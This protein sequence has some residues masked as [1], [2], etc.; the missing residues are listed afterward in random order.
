MQPKK[1][2]I[3]RTVLL[4]TMVIISSSACAGPEVNENQNDAVQVGI[5]ETA[6]N[7][8][9]PEVFPSSTPRT[10]LPAE[11]TSTS[12]PTVELPA[13]TPWP[14]SE[15]FFDGLRVTFFNNA[16]FMITTGDVKILIDVLYDTYPARTAP[17]RAALQR[18]AR[19][20]APFDGVD[21]IIATHSHSDHFSAQLVRD[22]LAV[23]P[24]AV[25]ISSPDAVQEIGSQ[26]QAITERLIPVSIR[27]GESTTLSVGGIDLEFF[28]IT[29][30]DDSILNMGVLIRANGYT[31]FHSGDMNV[32]PSWGD[33][34]SREDLIAFGLPEK[35]IDVAFLP[36]HIF[37]LEDY[38][39]LIQDGIHASYLVP[40]HYLYQYPPRGIEEIYP[41]AV[42]FSN[43]L[44]NWIMPLELS[45]PGPPGEPPTPDGVIT[46][47]E[48]AG[49]YRVNFPDQSSFS[50]LQDD[51]FLYLAVQSRDVEQGAGNICLASQDQVRLLHSSAALG[52]A[53]Y[54]KNGDEWSLTRKFDWKC[55]GTTNS[56]P[57][58]EERD[59]FLREYGWIANN[60][61][62]G[63]PGQMEYKIALTEYPMR[64][65][66]VYRKNSREDSRIWWPG[67]LVDDCLDKMLI[68]QPIPDKA[69][70][71]PG[72]WITVLEP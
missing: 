34:V 67:S 18:A 44:E 42:V 10:T 54:E 70:F 14:T 11:D 33:A 32:D 4:I 55:R 9:T 5:T 46:D 31:F 57:D 60:G 47:D 35:N 40:M 63:E 22:H 49:A 45:F 68:D 61:R 62:A 13:D 72:N 24:D 23:N 6:G 21:L 58:Q 65:A 17:D 29:H 27:D 19:A 36:S 15:A 12:V 2:S 43:T 3:I 51:K 16:G 8:H 56:A 52:T 41:N 20:Q 25:F 59:E 48:W 39:P 30:G 71:L 64:I 26:S 50:I 38:A 53:V 69:V 1:I 7:T 66:V 28:Y 37:L